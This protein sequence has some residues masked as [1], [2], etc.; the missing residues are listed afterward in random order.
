MEACIMNNGVSSHYF[1]LE[2]GVRQGDPLSPSLFILG[3]EPF[4]QAVDN[5]KDIKGI[6]IGNSELKTL[7]FADDTTGLFANTESLQY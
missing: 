2:R 5:C 4:A 3:L 6:Q 1:Q 7:L